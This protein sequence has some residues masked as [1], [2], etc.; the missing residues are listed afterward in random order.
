LTA[1]KKG[2]NMAT[3]LRILRILV[4]QAIGIVITTWGGITIPYVGITIGAAISGLFKFIR[5]KFPNSKILEW[6]PL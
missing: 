3:F 6:L 5:D 1:G 4:G 2:E